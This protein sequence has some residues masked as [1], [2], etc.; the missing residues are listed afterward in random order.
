[1]ANEWQSL[2]PSAWKPQEPN[3]QVQAAKAG[4]ETAL[5]HAQT[6]TQAVD[7]VAAASPR[8]L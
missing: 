8:V 5:A 6:A 4:A 2:L 7:A 3:T 1:M